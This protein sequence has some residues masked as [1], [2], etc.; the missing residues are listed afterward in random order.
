MKLIKQMALR[1]TLE[2]WIEKAESSTGENHSHDL[3]GVYMGC[4]LCQY[5]LERSKNS[6]YFISFGICRR[7]CPLYKLAP[8]YRRDFICE[9]HRESPMRHYRETSVFAK[10]KESAYKVAEKIQDVLRAFHMKV[11]LDVK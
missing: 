7:Y 2:L 11:Y 8:T 6:E 9:H 1:K 4:Y 3:G 10:R 5:T